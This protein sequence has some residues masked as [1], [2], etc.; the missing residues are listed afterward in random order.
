MVGDP[1]QRIAADRD[2]VGIGGHDQIRRALTDIDLIGFDRGGIIAGVLDRVHQPVIG[3]RRVGNLWPD[4]T[5]I[6]ADLSVEPF[7]HARHVVPLIVVST[8]CSR[9]LG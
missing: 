7:D 3:L 1:P 5:A 4:K 6:L 9:V 8:R 2:G